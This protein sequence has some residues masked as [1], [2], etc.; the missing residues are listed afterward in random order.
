MHESP[1]Y[2]DRDRYSPIFVLCHAHAFSSISIA[3]LGSH[4]EL[5]WFPELRLFNAHSL[6]EA[7]DTFGGPRDTFGEALDPGGELQ[8]VPIGE[9]ERLRMSGAVR[10]V[11]ELIFGGQSQE[12]V[13]LAWSWVRENRDM[14]TAEFFDRLLEKVS[15]KIGIEKSPDTSASEAHLMLCNDSYPRARF[16]HLVRHPVTATESLQKKMVEAFAVAGIVDRSPAELYRRSSRVWYTVN[17]RI[18]RFCESL[19]ESR[20]LRLRAEDLLNHPQDTARRFCEWAQVDSRDGSIVQMM[21]PEESPFARPGPAHAPGGE[22]DQ[23][24]QNPSI[25]PVPPPE[26]VKIPWHW[27]LNSNERRGVLELAAQLGYRE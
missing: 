20:V 19:D 9:T 16:V 18:V 1:T 8:D 4:P 27:E 6:G 23:F 24:L 14:S 2:R 11:A 22:H 12:S 10:S 21:H 17:H 5:Y 15:P 25:R 13:D 7:Q 3:I 26:P